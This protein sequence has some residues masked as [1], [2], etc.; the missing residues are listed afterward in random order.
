MC[1]SSTSRFSILLHVI[2]AYAAEKADLVP[3]LQALKAQPFDEPLLRM[4][5]AA[6]ANTAVPFGVVNDATPADIVDGTVTP[7][8]SHCY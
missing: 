6:T 8:A 2:F 1:R 4:L 3:L 5:L 7:A